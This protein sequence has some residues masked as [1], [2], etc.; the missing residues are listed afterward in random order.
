MARVEAVAGLPSRV[1]LNMIASLR[2]EDQ[3]FPR[4]IW[5]A[6]TQLYRLERCDSR[7]HAEAIEAFTVSLEA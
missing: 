1:E 7:R 3:R 4:G 6:C 5:E 2:S